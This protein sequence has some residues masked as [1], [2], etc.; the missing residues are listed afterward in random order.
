MTVTTNI[1]RND[2]SWL[3]DNARLIDLSGQLLGAHI[4]HAGL[5]IILVRVPLRPTATR[6]RTAFGRDRLLC[7]KSI[8]LPLIPR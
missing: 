6:G 8:A 2:Y 4:D 3:S 1:S 7:L 5:I